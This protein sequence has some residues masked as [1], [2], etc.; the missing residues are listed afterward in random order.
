M[1]GDTLYVKNIAISND[2]PQHV[3]SIGTP[4]NVYVDTINNQTHIEGDL[5]LKG[6]F[7]HKNPVRYADFELD[8]LNSN[9]LSINVTGISIVELL[10]KSTTTVNSAEIILNTN[11]DNAIENVLF[12]PKW[13]TYSYP[14]VPFNA[15]FFIERNSD[16]SVKIK[17]RFISIQV[18]TFTSLPNNYIAH[19]FIKIEV[20]S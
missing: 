7:V 14:A 11:I 12:S 1:P 17:V 2:N 16:T 5:Y 18:G 8:S 20:L 13:Q 6:N 19:L 9:F 4:S 10:V 3:L 15:S